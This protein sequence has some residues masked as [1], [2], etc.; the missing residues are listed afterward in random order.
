MRILLL[1]IIAFIFLSFNNRNSDF[2]KIY[3]TELSTVKEYYN[4][5]VFTD[6][7]N[8]FNKDSLI[9]RAMQLNDSLDS[10]CNKYTKYAIYLN[11]INSKKPDTDSIVLYENACF[12]IVFKDKN[13]IKYG[14]IKKITKDSLYI[15][16]SFNENTAKKSKIKYKILRY[17][18]SEIKKIK[19]LTEGGLISKSVSYKKF[20]FEI[21]PFNKDEAGDPTFFAWDEIGK[22]YFYRVWLTEKR[23]RPI[24]EINGRIYW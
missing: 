21:I 11:P 19:L 10:V 3:H 15:S 18:I 1:F 24:K 6:C 23:Y 7:V 8:I 16:N 2:I 4:N 13:H 14:V 17:P 5:H 22:I 20:N 12:N 9:K